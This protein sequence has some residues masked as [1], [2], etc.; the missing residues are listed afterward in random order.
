MN[1]P[2]QEPDPIGDAPTDAA[3]HHLRGGVSRRI[4]T[5]HGV[6]RSLATWPR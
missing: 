5:R 2:V 3:A 1:S 4:F 6:R